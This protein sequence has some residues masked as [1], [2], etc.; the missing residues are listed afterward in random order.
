MCLKSE[1]LG[2]E[3]WCNYDRN[4]WLLSYK[5]SYGEIDIEV[6]IYQE[7]GECV[8]FGFDDDSGLIVEDLCLFEVMNIIIDVK[9]LML[10]D[11]NG[12]YCL[13]FGV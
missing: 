3:S 7:V 2:G 6:V 9:V 4:Y 5:G 13:I 1:E 12:V 11:W 10:L 8:S